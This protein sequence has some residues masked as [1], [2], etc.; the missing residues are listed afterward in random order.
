MSDAYEREQYVPAPS[1]AAE[2][3]PPLIRLI[4]PSCH[5]A[6]LADFRL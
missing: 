4:W 3:N 5:R 2:A 6:S 1:E